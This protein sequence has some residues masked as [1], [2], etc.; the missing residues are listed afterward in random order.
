[1]PDRY[2]YYAFISYC[3]RDG[4][5]ARRLQASLERLRLPASLRKEDP[6]LPKRISPVFMDKSD[7]VPQGRLLQ[8]LHDNLDASRTLLLL[9]SPDSARSPWVDQ[10][11]RYFIETGRTDRILPVIL[12]GD[13]HA[14]DPERECFPPSLAALGQEDEP[15]AI[16]LSDYDGRGSLLRIAAALLDLKLD[17]LLERDAAYRRK[18]RILF[19][20]AAVLLACSAAAVLWYITPHNRSYRDYV[21]KQEIPAGLNEVSAAERGMLDYTYRITKRKGRVISLER[22]NSAGELLSAQFLPGSAE[23]P[24]VLYYYENGRLS[25]AEYIDESGQPMFQKKYSADLQ[26]VDFT[27]VGNDRFAY[28]LQADLLTAQLSSAADALSPGGRSD[29]IRYLQTYDGQGFLVTRL[30]KRD[31]RGNGG[32]PARD[33]NGVWGLQYTRDEAGRVVKEAYLDRDGLPMAAGTGESAHV[34]EYTADGALAGVT[35]VDADGVPIAGAGG[36]CRQEFSYDTAGRLTKVVY[37]DSEG[38]PAVEQTLHAA[39]LE[40]SY[41]GHGFLTELACYDD[42]SQPCRGGQGAFRTVLEND[43]K[44]HAVK[45]SFFDEN[46]QPT[47]CSDGYAVCESVVDEAGRLLE[48]RYYGPDGEPAPSLLL[49]CFRQRFTYENGRLVRIDSMD[50]EGAPM[51]IKNGSASVCYAYSPEG[52]KISER[53]LDVNGDPVNCTTGFAEVRCEY[54]DGALTGWSDYGADGNPCLNTNGVSSCRIEYENGLEARKSWFGTDGEPVLSSEGFAAFESEY[55]GNG[56]LLRREFLGTDGER[57]LVNGC[58]S[59]I[60]WSYDEVGRV[61][62]ERYYDTQDLPLAQEALNG[63]LGVALEYDGRGNL[64]A[65]VYLYAGTA[66]EGVPARKENTYDSHGN[67]VSEVYLDRDG[68]EVSGPEGFSRQELAYDSSDRLVEWRLYVPGTDEPMYTEKITNDLF[69]NPV[70]VES[71][72]MTQAGLMTVEF[73]YE[74]DEFGNETGAWSRMKGDEDWEAMR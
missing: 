33:A 35:A 42:L 21:L 27:L 56:L 51:A 1:M 32:T 19:A 57:I 68:N 61:I 9:C 74:Y 8:S 18:K 46:G 31:S 10:E 71:A 58:F 43:A 14:A 69:G 11:V 52:L 48:N 60:G 70:Y 45:A 6:S 47:P 62:E 12:D 44:G 67:A 38:N 17:K 64:A 72:I 66:G 5:E 7:L 49:G 39:I 2:E 40:L 54:L 28:T 59:A 29:I 24:R 63:A 22:V 16:R 15:T 41:D 20:S 73:R 13:P 65:S 3:S 53:Y 37:R 25:R 34:Y 55:D 26:A 36:I 30:F 23:A 4:A 50:A